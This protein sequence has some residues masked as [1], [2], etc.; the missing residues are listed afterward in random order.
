MH[1]IDLKERIAVCDAFTPEERD[2]IL[3]C[4]NIAP[5]PVAVEL[6]NP[7]N[8]LGRIEM[9]WAALSIDEGGE[10]VCAA[11]F[12]DMTLPLIAADKRRLDQIVPMARSIANVFGKPV[13]LAKFTKREDVEIYQPRTAAR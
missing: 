12:G 13:R 7:P 5:P 3:M 4:I 6:H 11:P 2:F 1:L 10:G 8:Y 9:I